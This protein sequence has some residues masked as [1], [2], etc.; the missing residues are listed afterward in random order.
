MAQGKVGRP[1]RITTAEIA[2]AALAIGLDRA[3]VRNVAERLGMSVPGLYHHVRSREELLAMAAA[4]SLGELS[5]P[6]DRGQPWERWLVDYAR[7]VYDALVEHPEIIGQILTGT[8]NTLRE[9][10]HLERVFEVLGVHG[11]SVA[12]AFDAY[13][14]VT[15]AVIGAA[16]SSIGRRAAIHAGHP[17]LDDLRR[18]TRALGADTVPLV[19]ALVRNAPRQIR[20]G[21]PFD[22]VRRVVAAIAAE[23]AENR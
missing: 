11:F 19:D 7:F 21:D 2:E 3:T 10:Q 1:A 8:V 23:R 16:A 12:E 9:A 5:L 13:T 20:Q 22:V 15:S 17:P 18:A 6:S 4:H 14:A